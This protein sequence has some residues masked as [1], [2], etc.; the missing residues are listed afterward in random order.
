MPPHTPASWPELIAH[1][2]QSVVTGQRL[3]TSFAFAVWARAGPELPTGKNSSG[4][5][6]RHTA[7]WRQSM[8]KSFHAYRAVVAV[9]HA[10]GVPWRGFLPGGGTGRKVN[11]W[12]TANLSGVPTAAGLAACG[13]PVRAGRWCRRWRYE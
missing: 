1:A 5:S 6:W 2:R 3:H 13:Q 9:R 11:G 8:I 10:T 12:L 4:S 7:L